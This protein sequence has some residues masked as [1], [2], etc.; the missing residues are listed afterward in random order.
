MEK[1]LSRRD[2]LKLGAAVV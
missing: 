2:F 1:P